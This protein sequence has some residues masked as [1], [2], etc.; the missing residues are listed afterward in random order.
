MKKET[1]F[2]A[3]IFVLAVASENVN[4]YEN[5]AVK[6]VVVD[7]RRPR[8]EHTT[9]SGMDVSVKMYGQ[10]LFDKTPDFQCEMHVWFLP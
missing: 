9:S 4:V 2:S 7:T 6:E 1:T 5:R 10:I 8:Q 3:K